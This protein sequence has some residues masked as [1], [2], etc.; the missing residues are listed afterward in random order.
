MKLF[1]Q[2][3][4]SMALFG[5]LIMTSACADESQNTSKEKEVDVAQTSVTTLSQA[6]VT[7]A[8][9]ALIGLGIFAK[10]SDFSVSPVPGYYQV[11][12]NSKAFFISQDGKYL[13][14]GLLLETATEVNLVEQA[15]A[16]LQA[17]KAKTLAPK[18]KS[19]EAE[20]ITYKAKNEKY[21]VTVFT[22]VTCGYCRKLHGQMDDYNDLGITVR[23]LAF[24]RGGAGSKSHKQLQDVW[25]AADRNTA[26]DEAK[27]TTRTK[28]A[29]CDNPVMEHYM[30]G[31]EFGVTGTPA[32]IM[33][34]GQLVPGYLEPERLLQ[35]LKQS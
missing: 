27:E 10:V 5:A 2:F 17:Q 7:E 21:V 8:Q 26:M 29:T 20:M 33:P 28:T 4:T 1:K 32:I 25:C 18:L 3:S 15:N 13:I 31:Q 9:E 19:A 23:Y 30:L 12:F 34:S 35:S 16:Q 11:Q 22:D 14:G 24:P 6:E